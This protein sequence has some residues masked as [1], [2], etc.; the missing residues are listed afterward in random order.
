MES[1]L[2]TIEQSHLRQCVICMD[3]MRVCLRAPTFG[4]VLREMK[5]NRAGESQ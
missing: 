2:T 5:K 3:V 1:E 4:A